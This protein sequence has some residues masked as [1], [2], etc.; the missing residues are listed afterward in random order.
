MSYK[1][2]ISSMCSSHKRIGQAVRELAELGFK[3]IELTGG[4]EYYEGIVGQLRE[5]KNEYGLDY[6]V[7]NYFPPQ[8]ESF[9]LNIASSDFTTK[10]KCMALIKSALELTK[11]FGGGVYGIHPG[12][13]NEVMPELVNGFFTKTSKVNPKDN[14]YRFL[15]EL[16][17]YIRDAGVKLAVENIAPRSSSDAFSFLT[18]ESA[19]LEFFEYI[20]GI[21]EIGFLFDMAHLN[22]A[23]NI[24]K[25]DKEK[26]LRAIESEYLDKIYEIHVSGDSHVKD[27]H[28]IIEKDSWQLIWLACHKDKYNDLPVVFEWHDCAS[29]ETFEKC[30]ELESTLEFSAKNA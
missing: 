19:I 3:N 8:K 16:R 15:E 26:I 2:Y 25:Y 18:A 24:L 20:S 22:V 12:F 30:V 6:M 28:L 21:D 27:T 5:L 10:K 7:H 1:F 11:E 17:P 13:I 14:V 9:V 4:T 23:G 29:K